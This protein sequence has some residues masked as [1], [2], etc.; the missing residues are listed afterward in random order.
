MKM[1]PLLALML[2]FNSLW[3][4]AEPHTRQQPSLS[5]ADYQLLSKAMKLMESSQ[6]ATAKPLLEKAASQVKSDY[7]KALVQHNLGQISLQQE[8]YQRAMGHLNKAYQFNALPSE[9]QINLLHTLGQL[10]CMQ[11]QWKD[12]VKRINE[13]AGKAPSKVTPNDHLML[14][15]A[16]SQLNNWHQV[17]PHISKAIAA[18]KIA[19]LHW[20]QLKVAAHARLK[21]W[22]SAISV[23]QVVINHYAT[24]A[25]Q[26]RQLVSLY[27]QRNDQ[28]GAL[29]TQRMGFARKLLRQGKDYRLLAQLML[30]N[31]LPYQAAQTLA[32]GMRRNALQT[33]QRQLKLLAQAWINAKETQQAITTLAQLNKIAPSA[34]TLQQQAQLQIQQQQ[35]HAAGKTLTQALAMS[36]GGQASEL[37]LMRGIIFINLKDYPNARQALDLA[38]SSKRWQKAAHNWLA[39]LNQINP[40]QMD[41]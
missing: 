19:P 21:Q 39:Y 41:S 10:H 11:A 33:D 3:L 16:Y 12:C 6:Y 15:Q 2:L 37:Q 25:Q 18:R 23:Q 28:K 36:R 13:W 17:I 30:N 24:D 14:A 26:W 8:A 31:H 38:A 4:H 32:E 20:Y 34:K 27:L 29:A 5:Q 40:P 9:Q 7:A 35:W 22:K 1:M